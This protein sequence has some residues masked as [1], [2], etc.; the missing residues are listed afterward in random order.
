LAYVMA[1]ERIVINAVG[2]QQA[3]F[4]GLILAVLDTANWVDDDLV[5]A[6]RTA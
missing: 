3:E 6:L 4:T 1:D 5:A 2:S